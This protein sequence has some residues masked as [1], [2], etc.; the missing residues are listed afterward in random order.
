MENI[1]TAGD[2]IANVLNKEFFPV[3]IDNDFKVGHGHTLSVKIVM[4]CY[5]QANCPFCFNKQTS[6]TQVHDTRAFFKNM[7]DS[8]EELFANIH[9]RRISLD[10]TGMSQLSM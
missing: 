7:K 5:C 9:D 8:L 10:I 6:E 4:P 3:Q 1:K 2:F